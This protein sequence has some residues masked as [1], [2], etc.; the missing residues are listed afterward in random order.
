MPNAPV[1][2]VTGGA[3]GIG[4]ATVGLFVKQGA[5]V[6]F[7]DIEEDRGRAVAAELGDAVLFRRADV[8][9]EADIAQL[10][11]TAVH[12]FGGL[13]CV[14]NNASTGGV[15]GPIADTPTQGFDDTIGLTLRS[16]FLGIKHAA[17]RMDPVRGGAVVNVAS[18][19]GLQAGHGSHAYSAAKSAIIV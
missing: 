10:F 15:Y 3:N 18:I 6:V 19:A 12:E 9:R 4:L 1:V 7:G 8:R 16:V 14:V 5:L 2:V 13:D 11:D 17:L